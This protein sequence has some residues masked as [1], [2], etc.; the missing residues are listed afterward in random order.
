MTRLKFDEFNPKVT[1]EDPFFSGVRLY[2]PGHH[3]F[4]SRWRR[5]GKPTI[6]PNYSGSESGKLWSDDDIE[7]VLAAFHYLESNLPK[8]AFRLSGNPGLEIFLEDNFVVLGS[9][10]NAPG[11]YVSIAESPSGKIQCFEASDRDDEISHHT[12]FNRFIDAVKNVL[13]DC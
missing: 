4:A 6:P 11:S 1:Y 2:G 3:S 7:E 9:Y 13:Y 8:Q 10:S 5:I 12:E